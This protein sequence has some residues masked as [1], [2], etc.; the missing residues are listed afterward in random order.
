M[1]QSKVEQRNMDL[2]NMVEVAS[3]PPQHRVAPATSPRQ[4]V[5]LCES[6]ISDDRKA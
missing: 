4:R 6:R 3:Q 5:N 1:V 2:W